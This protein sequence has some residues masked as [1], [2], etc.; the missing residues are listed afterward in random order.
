[1][2]LLV[3]STHFGFMVTRSLPSWA[4]S[5]KEMNDAKKYLVI[6]DKLEYSI[7]YTFYNINYLMRNCIG[8]CKFVKSASALYTETY[9]GQRELRQAI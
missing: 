1:M 8:W 7:I 6:F 2:T 4:L 3:C 5:L 9:L